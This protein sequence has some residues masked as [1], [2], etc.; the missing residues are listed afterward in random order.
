[1]IETE[2][3][4]LGGRNVA[5]APPT[6]A[7]AERDRNKGP[8][9]AETAQAF[10]PSKDGRGW[11][12]EIRRD[13]EDPVLARRVLIDSVASQ[14]GRA[15]SAL[16]EIQEQLGLELPGITITGSYSGEPASELERQTADALN[17]TISTWTAPHRQ[18][19]AW[20][21]F[22]ETADGE[23]VWQ[24]DVPDSVKRLITSTSAATGERLYSNFPNSALYGYWLSSGTASRH[25]LPRAYSSEIVG[26]GVRPVITGTTKLDAGGG[27]S[28][29][30]KV[31]IGTDGKL[32]IGSGNKPSSAGFGQ[33]PSQPVT[34]G[35]LCEL[36]LQQASL[37]LTM[38]RS[39]T[40]QD[41]KV[42]DAALTVLTLLGMTGHHLA[43]QD[44]FL[45]SSCSLVPITDRWGWIRRG[46]LHPEPLDVTG[47]DELRDALLEAIR[48][49]EALGLSFAEPVQLRFSEAERDLIE[50]RVR[51]E[52]AKQST[53]GE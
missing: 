21:R 7:G 6:Y 50:E 17:T 36:I 29:K 28:E 8:Q 39:L 3:I 10:V 4:P 2:L 53:E 14:S 38:L 31:K 15:E 11:Y 24:Q 42:K 18:A 26:F 45:R 23:Q 51:L 19:D 48:D 41:Q 33:V 47:F 5:V 43:G 37:S 9:F 12:R 13:G 27:A 32:S 25:K 46:D 30:S 35:Y 49:A 20:I 52:S 44:G 22:A 16:W 34:T 1:M 40:F